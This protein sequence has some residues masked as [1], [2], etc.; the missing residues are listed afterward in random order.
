MAAT[1]LQLSVFAVTILRL[2]SS[3][4]TIMLSE[5]QASVSQLV[6]AVAQLQTGMSQL[7]RNVGVIKNWKGADN[8]T[9]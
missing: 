8:V 6:T 4:P 3:Q 7:E 9:G 2:T 1:L 5:I